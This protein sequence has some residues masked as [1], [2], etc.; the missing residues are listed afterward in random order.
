VPLRYAVAATMLGALASGD[1]ATAREAWR[2]HRAALA[3]T[4][5]LALEVLVAQA[6][7]P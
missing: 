3:G 5:D 6:E 1:R 7:V 2:R 4:S